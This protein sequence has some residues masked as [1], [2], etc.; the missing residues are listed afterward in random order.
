VGESADDS[1]RY[2]IYPFRGVPIIAQRFSAGTFG[3][4]EF[5]SRQGR[6]KRSAGLNSWTAIFPS[7]KGLGYFQKYYDRLM[8]EGVEG[9]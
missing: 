8:Q 3:P 4:I 7:P 5:K 6:K 9:N 2:N 1:G